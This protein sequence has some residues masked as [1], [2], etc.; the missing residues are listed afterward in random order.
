MLKPRK[1]NWQLAPADRETTASPPTTWRLLSVIA[2]T[3]K[4]AL[5]PIDSRSRAIVS[6]GDTALLPTH[7]RDHPDLVPGVIALDE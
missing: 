2:L 1:H 6:A 5:V 3:A 7:E 4:Q